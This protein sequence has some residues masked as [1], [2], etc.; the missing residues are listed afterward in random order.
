MRSPTCTAIQLVLDRNEAPVDLSSA[1]IEQQDVRA[2]RG[3]RHIELDARV[4][5]VDSGKPDMRLKKRP[6]RK[7]LR[8]WVPECRSRQRVA[9]E[10]AHVI[11]RHRHYFLRNMPGR[12]VLLRAPVRLDLAHKGS[13]NA[14][15]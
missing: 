12:D 2:M 9:Y 8:N 3:L 7:H 6:A 5:S 1:L 10:V 11:E 13:V 15:R 14:S 4:R